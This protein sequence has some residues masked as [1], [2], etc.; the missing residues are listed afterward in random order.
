MD[1]RTGGNT[2][3]PIGTPEKIGQGERAWLLQVQTKVHLDHPGKYPLKLGHAEEDERTQGLRFGNRE[4]QL[5]QPPWL[6]LGQFQTGYQIGP[7]C[8]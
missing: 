8:L 1:R 7:I 6:I 5:P 3:L 4:Q 2:A